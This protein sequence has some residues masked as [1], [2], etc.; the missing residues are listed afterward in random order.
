MPVVLIMLPPWGLDTP[1]LGLASISAFLRSHGVESHIIDA[2]KDLYRSCP[3][4]HRYLWHFEHKDRWN[5]NRSYAAIA[6]A[7]G[8]MFDRLV[9]R[10]LAYQPEVV[11]FSVNQN[12]RLAVLDVAQRLRARSGRVTLVA[13]G[14]GVLNTF[15]RLILCRDRLFDYF[16]AGEGEQ[17]LLDIVNAGRDR[18]IEPLPHGIVPDARPCPPFY[19]RDLTRMP[20][21]T[22]EELDLNLYEPT[23][24]I[25]FSRGCVGSCAFCNDTVT[26]GPYRTRRPADVADEMEYHLHHNGTS[27]FVF[28]DLALN[29]NI[30]SLH[31][32]CALIVARGLPVEWSG[33]AIPSRHMSSEMLALLKKAGCQELIYGVE[34]GSDRILRLMKKTFTAE[35]AA[36]V[37]HRTARA[38]IDAYVNIIVGFPGEQEPDLQETIG[39]L[40]AMAPSLTGIASVNTCNVCFNS[41]LREHRDRHAVVLSER[42]EEAETGWQTADGSNTFEHRKDRLRRVIEELGSLGVDFRQTSIF[43][44]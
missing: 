5:D 21:P 27:R 4:E 16:C 20:W 23:I 31:E 43:E 18:A 9:D 2:C 42:P 14:M 19:H 40:R 34:S 8:H 22:F 39:L 13:G 10:V 38:G 1:P 6:G 11:G 35:H 37:V 30:K 32:L 25:L 7:L 3:E 26:M 17:P 44:A 15:E 41:W 29:G 12:N 28:N 24:P 33:N 36:Q